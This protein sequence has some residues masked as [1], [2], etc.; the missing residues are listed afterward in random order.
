[1]DLAAQF[2]AR[3]SLIARV[4]AAEVALARHEHAKAAASLVRG[5]TH[6]LGNQVQVLRLASIELERRLAGQEAEL[7]T[8]LRQAAE[9][10][11]TVL[12]DLLAAARPEV[13]TT[14]GP[15][16]TPTL[17][18]AIDQV[19]AATAV[20]FEAQLEV[21]DDVRTRATGDELAAIVF[22]VL[23]DGARNASRLRVWLRQRQIEKKP[24]IELLVIA[25]RAS[26]EDTLPFVSSAAQAAGGDA[27]ISDG[28]DGIELA[29]ELPV[30][31]SSSSS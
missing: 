6:E 14:T 13:R 5:R 31:Q 9:V 19:R 23:L 21:S 26:F 29:I 27:S 10:A 24:W 2:E 22:S 18:A 20:P 1:M 28:R 25:D 3:L 8:D 4:R 17:R 16:V 12:G 7:L 11:S 15:A 30:A